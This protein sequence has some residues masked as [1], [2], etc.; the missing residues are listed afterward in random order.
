MFL[1]V[2]FFLVQRGRHLYNG[3]FWLQLAEPSLARA[4]DACFTGLRPRPT[5]IA[6]TG[7]LDVS[8]PP[9]QDLRFLDGKLYLSRAAKRLCQ[10]LLATFKSVFGEDEFRGS[11]QQQ[12][13]I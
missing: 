12:Y 4:Q 13:P 9:P 2:L 10:R 7:S 6:G 11:N 8:F 5:A 1:G 3:N